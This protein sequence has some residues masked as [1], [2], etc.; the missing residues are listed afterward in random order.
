MAGTDH[1]FKVEKEKGQ[2][3]GQREELDCTAGHNST[4]IRKEKW[5]EMRKKRRKIVFKQR[6][7]RDI[8]EDEQKRND[9]RRI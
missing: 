7:R 3:C 1:C 2:L 5:R 4:E 8:A 9:R 6:R